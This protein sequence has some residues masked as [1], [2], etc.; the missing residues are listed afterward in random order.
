MFCF[1]YPPLYIWRSKLTQYLIKKKCKNGCCI[2]IGAP[3]NIK[4][5]IFEMR[6]LCYFCT[7]FNSS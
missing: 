2:Y 6:I 7:D 4:T 3:L 5:L 1:H